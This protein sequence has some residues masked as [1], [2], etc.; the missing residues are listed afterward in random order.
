M[1]GRTSVVALAAAL[2]AATAAPQASAAAAAGSATVLQQGKGQGNQGG[3]SE[4]RGRSGE[5]RQEARGQGRAQQS[6]GG[7]PTERR[8]EA[9]GGRA[10]ADRPD[11]GGSTR[12]R[13]AARP[14]RGEGRSDRTVRESRG[15][16]EARS[17]LARGRG[18][19]SGAESLASRAVAR[20]RGH[21]LAGDAVTVRSESGRTRLLNRRGDVLLEMDDDRARE[22]GAWRMRRLGDRRPSRNAPAFCRNGEGHPVWGRDW[23]LQKGFGLGS[24]QGTLWSRSRIDDVIF[25]RPVQPIRLDRGGLLDVLGDLV[26][27]RL[28]LHSVAMGYQEPLAGV[29]VT[30]PTAPRLL[31][32]YSGDQPVA[33][34]VDYDRDDRVE[35]L[36]VVQPL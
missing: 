30:D 25:R 1:I 26:L 12:G 8:Q 16:G 19:R 4:A 20:G 31:R 23:C 22:M 15:S 18:G 2:A 33:E 32:V 35:V 5:R 14:E 9:R 3:G 17:S 10:Q 36:Y 27:G 28:A 7:R 21:G 13:S 34:F 11:R 6:T 24:R 29:W